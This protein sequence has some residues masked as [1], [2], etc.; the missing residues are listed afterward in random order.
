MSF[1]AGIPTLNIKAFT[2]GTAQERSQF[3]SDLGTAYENIGFVAIHGH[4]IAD[5]VIRD[6]YTQS[7]DFFGLPAEAKRAYARPE[8]KN[9]RGFVSMA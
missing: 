4:D 3:V 9:Q 7:E 2:N 6:L 8:T 5:A 1:V